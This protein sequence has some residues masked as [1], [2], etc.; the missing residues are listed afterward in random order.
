MS[1]L[2]CHQRD[3]V[4]QEEDVEDVEEDETEL[5]ELARAVSLS[6]E[7]K[8]DKRL[9]GAQDITWALINSPSFLFNR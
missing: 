9:T 3:A 5:K 6:T 7:Q 8:K 2:V 4:E 1:A